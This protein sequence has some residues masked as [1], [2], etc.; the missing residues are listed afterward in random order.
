MNGKELANLS[1]S[2][3]DV[4]SIS[5]VDVSNY[6]IELSQPELVFAQLFTELKPTGIAV[7]PK[8]L[9]KI[10]YYSNISEGSL[11]DGSTI[12]YDA[13]TVQ[14]VKTGF[15]LDLPKTG[16][17]PNIFG[18]ILKES[19]REYVTQT[20][21]RAETVLLN[22]K[23]DSATFS[24]DSVAI[25]NYPIV[26]ITNLNGSTL[27]TVDKFSGTITLT[28]STSNTIN[29]TYS[30]NRL[31]DKVSNEGTL[32]ALDLF[33]MASSMEDN[34]INADVVIVDSSNF[35][36]LLVNDSDLFLNVKSYASKDHLFNAECGMVGNL[37]V[38]LSGLVPDN[39]AIVA[40]SSK[41]GYNVIKRNLTGTK[42]D[43]PVY[44]LVSYN[45][46][47]EDQFVVGN[48]LAIGILLI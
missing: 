28:D 21:K 33:N 1:L 5:G 26:E 14:T 42:K 34:T 12:T 8:N 36:N 22:L 20:D 30:E 9:G 40:E 46:Y 4:T 17:T 31:F 48:S 10:N 7:I 15:R 39:I 38:L 44:D 16:L 29:Y 3:I 27:S 24:S 23:T 32:R 43:L 35:K 41:I 45:L 25:V 47:K 6:I 11:L 18:D 2:T 37:S 13:L 19:N